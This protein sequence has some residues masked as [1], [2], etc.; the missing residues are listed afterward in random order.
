[1]LLLSAEDRS[2][3][4]TQIRRSKFPVVCRMLP[5]D[6]ACSRVALVS[7]GAWE[8]PYDFDDDSEIEFGFRAWS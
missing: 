8:E 3:Q 1:M 4:W 2:T 7:V 6:F 5:S